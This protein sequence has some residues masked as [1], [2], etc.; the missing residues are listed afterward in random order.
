MEGLD[1][2]L[3]VSPF[4]QECI[5]VVAAEQHLRGKV[6]KGIEQG[7]D[8]CRQRRLSV[9][10]RLLPLRNLQ[11]SPDL[12]LN[13]LNLVEQSYFSFT[14]R[15]GLEPYLFHLFDEAGP[16]YEQPVHLFRAFPE[17]DRCRIDRTPGSPRQPVFQPK[18]SRY[19][20]ML[21][22]DQGGVLV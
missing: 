20:R 1:P 15:T 12:P 7:P 13:P 16:G 10:I 2:D 3:E 8:L 6:L 18:K 22:L 21:F 5:Q 4:L 19:H 11:G 9:A 14:A 17:M